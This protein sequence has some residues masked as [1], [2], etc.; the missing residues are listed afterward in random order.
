MSEWIEFEEGQYAV[1]RAYLAGAGNQAVDLRDPVL[2]IYTGRFGRRQ[3]KGYGLVENTA[4][5]ELHEESDIIDL[6]LDLG[7]DFRFMMENPTL[8]AG[9]VF[10]PGVRSLVHFYP[11]K[12]WK[13]LSVD[14]FEALRQRLSLL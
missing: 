12:P 8:H 2:E 14:D 13:A 4:L 1:S 5:V 6:L 7:G 11:Q 3:M 10:S 9:K